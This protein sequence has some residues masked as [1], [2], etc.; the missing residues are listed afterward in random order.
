MLKIV[1]ILLLNLK[2]LV[3]I[4]MEQDNFYAIVVIQYL[5]KQLN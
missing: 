2:D 3:I 4:V 5:K 1:I